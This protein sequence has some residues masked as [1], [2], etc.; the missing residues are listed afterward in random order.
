MTKRCGKARYRDR[1][2]ALI[3]LARIRNSP[4]PPRA[5]EPC[6]AYPCPQCKG[7]HLTSKPRRGNH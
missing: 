6:R 1:V 2:A 3:A 5:K 4:R 7:W